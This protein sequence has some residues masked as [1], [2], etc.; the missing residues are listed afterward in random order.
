MRHYTINVKG[1]LFDLSSPVVMGILNV[2]PDSFYEGSRMQTTDQII[3]RTQEILMEG[4]AII[5]IG[6]QSTRPTSKLLTA[7]EEIER[8]DFA[9]DIII[10]EYPDAVLSVDTFYA[11]VAK[12][13]VE[14]YNVAIIND[15]SGG[16]IDSNMFEVVSKLNVPYILMHMRGTPQTMKDLID[17]NNY[18]EDIYRYF[19]EKIALLRRYGVNDIIL[20]PGF[21][22]SKNLDQNYELMSRLTDFDIFELPL[23][24]GVSRKSMIY[25]LLGGS[26]I[27]SLNG[28]TVLNTYALLNGANILRVHDVKHAVEA[29]KIVE[30][31]KQTK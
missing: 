12:F 8:L 9:L 25:N 11:S 4:G 13:C 30:K 24:V 17:Y 21:G 6:A 31:L 14:K 29:V 27:E 15:I 7:D 5:D 18:P 28:T 22:F 23:L 16:Q 3:S 1:Q 20:D 10:K 2:T 19:A 26:P